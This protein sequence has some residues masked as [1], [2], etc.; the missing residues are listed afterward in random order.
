MDSLDLKLFYADKLFT[1]RVGIC[2]FEPEGEADSSVY[3]NAIFAPDGTDI[4]KELGRNA[5]ASYDE[6]HELWDVT[7]NDGLSA[8]IFCTEPTLV[9]AA[10]A[11]WLIKIKHNRDC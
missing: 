2:F 8:P 3:T 1:Q 7:Y 11:V 6:K 9:E 5:R 10:A 4:L